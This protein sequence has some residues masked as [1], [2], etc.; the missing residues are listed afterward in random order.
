MT[1]NNLHGSKLQNDRADAEA[2]ARSGAQIAGAVRQGA[3]AMQQSGQVTND[4]I[5]RGVEASAEMTRQGTQAG[6]E[7]ARRAS[8]TANETVR[9][10]TQAVAEGQ[11]QIAQEAAQT[12]QEVSRKV[13]QVAQGTSEEVRRL[14]TLPHAAE[15]GLRDLQH[16]IAGLVEGVMQTNLRATQELFRLTNP[17]AIIELQQRF[18]RNYLDTV[19][20]STATLVRAVRRTA[21]ETLHPLE[22]QVAQRQQVRP[23]YRT[24]AE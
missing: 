21:D 11:R 9:R 18:A 6:V 16:G 13:A 12:F 15:G 19:M 23:G 5:R 7:A 1:D 2:A 14:A 4:A 8:E 3:A 22:A 24:A 17:T 10:T 20:Q